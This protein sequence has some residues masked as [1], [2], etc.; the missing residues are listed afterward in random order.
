MASVVLPRAGGG[1]ERF[2]LR[3]PIA[4]ETPKGG[5]A[6]NRVAYAAAHVVADPFADVDPWLTA[7]IDWDRTIAFRQHLWRHGFGIAEAMDTTVP[8]VKSLLV[9]ARISLAEASQARMLTC[10]EVRVELAEAAEGL[11]KASGPVR[12]HVRDCEECASFRKQLRNDNKALA[13]QRIGIH[14]STLRQK[15]RRYGLE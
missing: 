11:A 14:R 7:A 10:G 13:A 12:R 1:T 4:F 6:L 3:A 2:E 15:L 8:S 5:S 9:R